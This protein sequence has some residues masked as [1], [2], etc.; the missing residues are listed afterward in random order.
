[1]IALDHCQD[2]NSPTECEAAIKVSPDDP[3]YGKY[4]L[5]IL[6]FMRLVTSANYSCPLIP[7]TILNQNTHYI[8]ASNV[9]GSD[10]KLAKYLR[11]FKKGKLLNQ[12][13]RKEEYCPQDLSKIF[14]NGNHTQMSIA[15]LADILAAMKYLL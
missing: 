2:E 13:I 6:K 8:D 7:N 15:F 10:S 11:F 12:M 5:T 4:N 9:Y 3:V 1:M 14:K